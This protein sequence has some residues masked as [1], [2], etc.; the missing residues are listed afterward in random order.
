M[1]E[2]K[3]LI[4]NTGII[5]IG[6]L[7]TKLISFLLLPLYTACLSAEEFGTVDYI[8]SISTFCVPFV[9]FLMDEAIFR[10]L[11]DCRTDSDRKVAASSSLFLV[12]LGEILF[13]LVSVPILIAIQY[14]Y[15]VYLI[16]Y[17]VSAV[18]T[19]MTSSLIRGMG[20]T[21]T[22]VVLSFMVSAITLVLNVVLIAFLHVGLKGML[23]SSIVAHTVVPIIFICRY[24][25]WNLISFKGIQKQQIFSMIKYSVPLIPNK[26]SWSII[27]LSD[28]IMIM[29]MI[30]SNASGLYAAAYKFPNLVD[31]VYGFF[32]QSW[33]ESSARA[34][35]HEDIQ[36]FYNSTYKYLKNVMYAF[37]VGLTAFMP[38]VFNILINKSYNDAI[39]YVP[40]LVL[41]TY[42]SNISGFYGGIF[43]AY[44]DTKVMGTTTILAAIINIVINIFLI[45]IIGLYAATISTLVANFVVYMYRKFRV[46]QYV[47]LEEQTPKSILAIIVMVVIWLLFYSM[48]TEL[49]IIGYAIAMIY[50]VAVNRELLLQIWRIVKR[51]MKKTV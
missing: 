27:N 26:I 46:K 21:S 17:V 47:K 40:P 20:K 35:H 41:A 36:K 30:G 51:R 7:S 25:L 42:F 37:V 50:A 43:T 39:V 18:L 4:K 3:R 19:Q 5:A 38:L 31:T 48:K 45:R 22:F 33:K 12:L 2:G 13:I 14:K 16:L 1:N 8:V 29:N 9:S 49:H 23:I 15:A 32:Y 11:I 24:Q 34:L 6:S 10:F 44:K 28:R